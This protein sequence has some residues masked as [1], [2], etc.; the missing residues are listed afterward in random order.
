MQ[1]STVA[2]ELPNWEVWIRGQPTVAPSARRSIT[3][4]KALKFK[5]SWYVLYNWLEARTY[6][7]VGSIVQ[8]S[9]HEYQKLSVL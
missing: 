4:L 8:F 3:W 2:G 9:D 6:Q 1:S 5:E 7:T